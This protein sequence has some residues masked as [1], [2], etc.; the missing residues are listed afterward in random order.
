MYILVDAQAAQTSIKNLSKALK[1]SALDLQAGKIKWVY[2]ES[3]HAKH[4][5]HNYRPDQLILP[6]DPAFIPENLFPLLDLDNTLYESSQASPDKHSPASSVSEPSSKSSDVPELAL[7]I[8]IPES[9]S[10]AESA[11]FYI[12]GSFDHHGLAVDDDAIMLDDP[13][14]SFDTDGHYFGEEQETEVTG[15]I[16][17]EVQRARSTSQAVDNTRQYH[18][19]GFCG[20]E[21]VSLW[22][23]LVFN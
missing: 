5:W 21:N 18:Q 6:D 3:S 22:C 8:E 1:T 20:E 13:G 12:P 15:T 7:R 17:T 4:W 19:G 23:F 14:F 10:G 2:H 9:V 11:P 16:P